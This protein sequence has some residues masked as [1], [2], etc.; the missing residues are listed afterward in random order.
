M[1]VQGDLDPVVGWVGCKPTWVP[2]SGVW[3]GCQESPV[4]GGPG[5]ARPKA[6]P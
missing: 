4:R 3:W 6:R 1:A 2:I 5:G